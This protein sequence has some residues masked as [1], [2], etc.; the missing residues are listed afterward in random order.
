MTQ[1]LEIRKAATEKCLFALN[2]KDADL[3][4]MHIQNSF[5][6][7]GDTNVKMLLDQTVIKGWPEGLQCLLDH[8]ADPSSL[9]LFFLARK[10]TSLAILELLAKYGM[11]F[12]STEE[13]LLV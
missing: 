4:K 1:D 9:S 12:H 2:S 8:G 11:N 13:N 6:Q 10:C 7:L 3:F 5:D